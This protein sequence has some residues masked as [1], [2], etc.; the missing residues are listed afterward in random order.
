MLLELNISDTEYGLLVGLY[1]NILDS[2]FSLIS[3]LLFYLQGS[4]TS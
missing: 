1:S 3:V 2:V 4:N